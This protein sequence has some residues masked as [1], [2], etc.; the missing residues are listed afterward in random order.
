[1]QEEGSPDETERAEQRHPF[2]AWITT[3]AR[4][5]GHTGPAGRKT[6]FDTRRNRPGTKRKAMRPH[7]SDKRN[8][9]LKL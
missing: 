2:A 7:A 6:T 9:T 8:R 3:R 1:M 5:H 4:T